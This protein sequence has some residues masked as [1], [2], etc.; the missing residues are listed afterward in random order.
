LID[1]LALAIVAMPVRYLDEARI[2]LVLKRRRAF[3][4]LTDLEIGSF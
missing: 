3:R 4:K 1:R 2:G